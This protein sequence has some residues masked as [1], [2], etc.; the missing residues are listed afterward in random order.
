MISGPAPSRRG[1]LS[2]L[3]RSALVGVTAVAVAGAAFGIGEGI[4]SGT[5]NPSP[6]SAGSAQ[7]LASTNAPAGKHHWMRFMHHHR[8]AAWQIAAGLASGPGGFIGPLGLGKVTAVGTNSITVTTA[9]GVS[10]QVKTNGS[11]RYFTML[12][13]S[14]RATV[15]VGEEVALLA[16]AMVHATIGQAKAQATTKA[17][18]AARVVVVIEPYV[19]GTVTST[20]SSQIVVTGNGGLAR[21]VLVNG[22]TAYKEAG[23][24]VSANAVK[25]GSE[26]FAYGSAASDPTKLQ[27]TNVLIIGPRV[28]G[29]V[30]SVS[31]ST[32]NVRT[33]AGSE[34]ITTTSS[35]IF[36]DG[37]QAGSLGDVAKGDIVEAIGRPGAGGTFS[38]SAVRIG[39]KYR[40][41]VAA[42]APGAPPGAGANVPA[43]V[44][45]Q[46]FG[47]GGASAGSFGAST[48]G[49]AGV[50]SS[51][52]G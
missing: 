19:L 2:R 15:K 4:A 35:T 8:L 51:L 42:W 27:A 36:R 44:Q 1:R 32:I 38:A 39:P 16:P 22:S 29:V 5:G 13:R 45:A 52:V 25:T 30:K 34:A 7:V 40:A 26:I 28:A 37:R 3:P 10:R 17:N 14:N 18:R 33:F 46:M 24:S 43:G 11:T 31:G 47:P 12:T 50:L 41:A 9:S 23:T 20:S 21:D 6:Q 48:T 49:L